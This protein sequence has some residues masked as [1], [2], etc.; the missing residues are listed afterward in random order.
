MSPATD[1]LDDPYPRFPHL[2]D[3]EGHPVLGAPPFFGSSVDGR[4]GGY[5]FLVYRGR[6]YRL[7]IERRPVPFEPQFVESI[8][9]S[10]YF[11]PPVAAYN[12][13][14]LDFAAR[15]DAV[16]GTWADVRSLA[17]SY[18][19]G[20]CDAIERGLVDPPPRVSAPPT[21]GNR[22]EAMEFTG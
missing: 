16:S 13:L 7:Y 8:T 12:L 11:A 5:F 14:F 20:V 1:L 15:L 9:E 19:K 21:A 2:E 10:N 18:L 6:R 22:G 3:P 17:G 4:A